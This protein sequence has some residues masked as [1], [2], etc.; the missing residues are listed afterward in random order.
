ML[1][2]VVIQPESSNT[3]DPIPPKSDTLYTNHTQALHIDE[4]KMQS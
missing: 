2:R 1:S 4:Q 3:F